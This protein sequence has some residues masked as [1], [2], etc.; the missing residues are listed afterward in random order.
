[1]PAPGPAAAPAEPAA[2]AP[3][4]RPPPQRQ[5][6]TFEKRKVCPG[7][8]ASVSDQTII[9]VGCGTNLLTGKKMKT[10]TE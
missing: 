1:A 9:C 10:F 4:K 8:K 2:P 5:P 7:C 6:E 3:T